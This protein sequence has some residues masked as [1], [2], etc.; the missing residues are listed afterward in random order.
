MSHTYA[1]WSLRPFERLKDVNPILAPGEATFDCPF[2]GN[3]KWEELGIFNPA[4]VVKDDQV[5][6]VYRSAGRDGFVTGVS[7]LG[8]AWSTDGI[9]FQ[10]HPEP[11]LY[12]EKGQWQTLEFGTGVQDPRIIETESGEYVLTYAMFDG[13][14]CTMAVATSTDLFHWEKRGLTFSG[15]YSDFWSKAGAIVCRQEGEKLIAARINGKYWMYWGESDIYAATSA[16]LIHWEPVEM[17]VGANKRIK[18][19]NGLWRD[20]QWIRGRNELK[21]VLAPR[22]GR[23]DS[24]LVEPG[25]AALLTDAGILLIYNGCNADDPDLSAGAY[26]V[27]QALFDSR[28]PTAVIG[29]T[30]KPFLKPELPFE[31]DGTIPNV[32]FANGL[33]YFKNRWLLY[34]G[35][36]DRYVGVCAT[37][38]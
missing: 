28:D 26:S 6:C 32:T 11:V 27:G 9:N 18:L 7:R 5:F 34:Y 38:A 24:V 36:G 12:P 4:V 29:R 30:T 2:L 35:A 17:E 21:P 31:I 22:H 19:E 8:L 20:D 16:D 3:V 25:P 23:F 13:T 1:A 37:H 10:R 14:C 33:V 15:K